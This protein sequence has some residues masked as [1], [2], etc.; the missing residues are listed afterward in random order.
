MREADEGEAANGRV[1]KAADEDCVGVEKGWEERRVLYRF[2]KGA[3]VD[4]HGGWA[5]E[6]AAARIGGDDDNEGSTNKASFDLSGNR[7]ASLLASPVAD[8]EG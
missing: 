8:L 1:R 3:K 4:G 7:S 5:R 2:G 6:Q